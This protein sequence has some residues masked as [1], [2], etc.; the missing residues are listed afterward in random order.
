MKNIFG[1][2]MPEGMRDAWI[3]SLHYALGSDQITSMFRRDTGN[4]WTPAKNSLD[5]MID[6]AVGAER[7]F[8]TKFAKW[9]NENIWGEEDG[10]PIDLDMK[11]QPV[12]ESK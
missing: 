6:K 8:L 2:L 10:M 4:Q 7:D 12:K 11:P 1:G 5:A 9:H 3:S